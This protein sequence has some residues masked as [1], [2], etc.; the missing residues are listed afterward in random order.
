MS[1]V[2][3]TGYPESDPGGRKGICCVDVA[4]SM[5]AGPEV[6]VR[7]SFVVQGQRPCQC[8][9]PY[10]SRPPLSSAEVSSSSITLLPLV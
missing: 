8:A 10:A 3:L 6:Y 7:S 1:A 5:S 4:T 2:I 9:F